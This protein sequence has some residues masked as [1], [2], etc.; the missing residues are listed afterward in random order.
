MVDGNCAAAFV[1]NEIIMLKRLKSFDIF[2]IITAVFVVNNIVMITPSFSTPYYVVLLFVLVVLLSRGGIQRCNTPM[3]LLMLAIVCSLLFNDVPAVF[4]PWM[5]FATFV[6][7]TAL[8]SPLIG[9]RPLYRFRCE[10]FVLLQYLMVI[11]TIA[12]F[13][14]YL[15]GIN[16]MRGD[17]G[18]QTGITSH[19]MILSPIAGNTLI[20]CLYKLIV[21]RKWR[22]KMIVKL[23]YC[24]MIA[25][26]FILVWVTLS[27]TTVLAT[28]AGVVALILF[29]SNF[30]MG[31]ASRLI[32][33]LCAVAVITSPIWGKYTEG[34][35]EKNLGSERAGSILS[36]REEH[37]Q[38]RIEEFKS[39]PI[40]GIGFA[41]V[42]F[43][44][45]RNV[46]VEGAQVRL[47]DGKVETGNSWLAVLSMT[48]IFGF[49]CF[50]TLVIKSF[51]KSK[52]IRRF[53]MSDPICLIG[54]LLAF[55]SVHMF[56]EG[57]IFGAGGFI[58]F[59][60]WLLLGVI[61][62]FDKMKFESVSV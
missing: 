24:G 48:G 3:V 40:F 49:A 20:F 2:S 62:A 21:E 32:I 6:I 8:V 60:V 52:R 53:K 59:N 29:Q 45:Q 39:S 11:V 16:Y 55:F 28:L 56:A 15:A 44:S 41:S 37:W 18:G 1:I 34:I 36:S 14:F 42:D 30:R 38:K 61:N 58:F 51:F 7:V 10:T 46:A 25:I 50:A 9:S 43:D 23:F 12:S 57:Y 26:S 54:S 13:L 33:G 31:K 22:S 47:D 4:S 27:R 35:Q 19:S 17:T 5:R